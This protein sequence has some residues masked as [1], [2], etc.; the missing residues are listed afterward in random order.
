[1]L[2]MFRWFLKSIKRER[3]LLSN[4]EKSRPHFQRYIA[5]DA[6]ISVAII[7]AGFALM[8]STLSSTKASGDVGLQ[9]MSAD[10][11]LHNIQTEKRNVYWLGPIQGDTYSDYDIQPGINVIT[12]LPPDADPSDINQPELSVKTYKN[13]ATYNGQVHPLLGSNARRIVNTN[14]T[15]VEFNE[16]TLDREI[17]IFKDK[18]EVIVIRYPTWQPATILMDNAEKLTLIQ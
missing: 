1:M 18:P 4:Y 8:S 6:V 15:S 11:L 14:G 3:L 9:R 7:L 2:A 12:Y 10:D 16:V 5:I 17:V 13:I